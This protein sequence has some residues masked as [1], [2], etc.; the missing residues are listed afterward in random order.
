M[1]GRPLGKH[2]WDNDSHDGDND[3]ND[4]ME[5]AVTMANHLTG[6]DTDGHHFGGHSH[7][8]NGYGGHHGHD[9]ADGGG[10][11]GG[12]GGDGGGWRLVNI[13][14]KISQIFTFFLISRD[15]N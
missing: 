14:D 12:G 3:Q 2:N 13:S 7:D 11:D 8:D 15:S 10:C 4:G 9:G 1:K 5:W 6:N